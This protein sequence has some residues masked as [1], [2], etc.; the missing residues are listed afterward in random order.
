MVL[1]EGL[2]DADGHE[3]SM[4]GLLPLK[5]SFAQR[6]RHLGYRRLKPLDASFFTQ[7]M[8]GHEFHY[9]TAVFEGDADRLFTVEDALGDHLGHVG[10]RR[11]PVAGSYMHIID[12]AGEGV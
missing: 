7:T 3:H 9:S 4:L 11:G 2:I 1:G 8:T 5:T 6:K 10:L 12:V